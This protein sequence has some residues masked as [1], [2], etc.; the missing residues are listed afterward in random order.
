LA[1]RCPYHIPQITGTG[2]ACVDTRHLPYLGR[3]QSAL[4]A[5]RAQAGGWG[6][7]VGALPWPAGVSPTP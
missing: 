5:Q 3:A 4:R 2:T 6:R 7:G 1:C